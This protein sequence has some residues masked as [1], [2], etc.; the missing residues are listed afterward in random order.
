M[1]EK[2]EGQ[3]NMHDLTQTG[4]YEINPIL[5]NLARLDHQKHHTT[6]PSH[7]SQHLFG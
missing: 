6:F 3:Y 5:Y 4:P 7:V 1:T 2:S